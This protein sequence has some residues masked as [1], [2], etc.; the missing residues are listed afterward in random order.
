M[1]LLLNYAYDF[2]QKHAC[3]IVKIAF[4]VSKTK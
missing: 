3:S 1:D 4:N 2:E